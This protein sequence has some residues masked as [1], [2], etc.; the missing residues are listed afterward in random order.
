VK[1]EDYGRFMLWLDPD[2]ERAGEIY[3][4]LQRNLTTYFLGRRCGVRAEELASVTLD[5]TAE[6]FTDGREIVDREPGR[7]IFLVARN[8][9]LEFYKKAP[10]QPLPPQLPAPLPERKDERIETPCWK[11]CLAGLSMQERDVLQDYY[12]GEKKGEGKRIRSEMAGDFGVER[13]ALRVKVFRLKKKLLACI[14]GCLKRM[15]AGGS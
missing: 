14:A 4:R 12:Q 1:P 7:F 3:N 6:K 15:P 13:G 9:L 10:M 2:P 5:R 11:E 8:V